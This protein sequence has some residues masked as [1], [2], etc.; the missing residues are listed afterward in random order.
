MKVEEPGRGDF[1]RAGTGATGPGGRSLQWLQEGRNKRSV[2][3]DLRSPR[4]Q[5]LL[6]SLIPHF[7]IVISNFRPP[8]LEKWGLGPD[9]L[10]AIS[11]R[12][13]YV[14]L[15][16][17][18]LTGPYRDRG[19]F[20]RIASAFSGL[21]F[22]SGEQDRPPVRTG[23][24]VI[25]FMGAYLSAFAAMVA[26][27]HRDTNGGEGQI[28]DLALYEAG[29][30]ASEGALMEY[31][32][33]QTIRERQGHRN[34]A[35][36]PASDFDTA[37]GRRLSLHAGT[38]ALFRRLVKVLGRMEM[39]DDPR[40]ATREARVRHQDEMYEIVAG[41]V[42]AR[43]CDDIVGELN[44]AGVPSAPIMNIA[45]IAQNPHCR[46]RGTIVSV[47]DDEF[48]RLPMA[49]PLPHLSETPGRIRTLGPALGEHNREVLGNLLGLSEEDLSRLAAEGVISNFEPAVVRPSGRS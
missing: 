32:W 8:T 35:I 40:F 9:V 48:G 16:G 7:D 42:R 34:P 36:A 2:T 18:G 27:R 12:S 23:Y 33:Q 14:F 25:D 30:R 39:L 15:T 19:A 38:D 20:D 45:D 5:E 4:G 31:G 49:A 11:P 10:R 1:T 43:N 46:E 21:T 3:I 41:W 13:I 28:V 17:Y 24:A 44:E 47:D 29:F 22:V 26:L 6:R 37:D